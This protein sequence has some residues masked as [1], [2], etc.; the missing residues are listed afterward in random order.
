MAQTKQLP[1]VR[2][3][4]PPSPRAPAI[5]IILVSIPPILL[6]VTDQ[7][8]EGGFIELILAGVLGWGMAYV[9]I[10]VTQVVLRIREPNARRP[11]RSPAWPIPQVVGSV[12]LVVAMFNIFPDP[13]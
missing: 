6:N 10:H 5:G 3:G 4:L 8:L 1:K 13:E 12:L 7:T 11:Y 2:G 9:I